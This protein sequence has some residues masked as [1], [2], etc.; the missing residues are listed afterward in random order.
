MKEYDAC[1]QAFWNGY[2]HAVETFE[3][4][5]EKSQKTEANPIEK[6]E[7]E[8]MKALE[9]C[10]TDNCGKHCP[11]Y[12]YA[13]CMDRLDNLLLD[14]INRKNAEIE[15][16]KERFEMLDSNSQMA[17][18]YADA[19]EERAR[20]EAIKEVLQRAR[21]KVCCIPQHHFTLEQVLC[22]IDQIAKEMGVEL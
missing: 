19:L 21:G 12:E 14:L 7:A 5:L 20:A 1:E 2:R 16:Y 11:F 15:E 8:I 22:D 9:C 3:K 18:G 10:K 4:S 13:D 6:S 17:I